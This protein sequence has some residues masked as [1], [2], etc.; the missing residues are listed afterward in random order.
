MRFL[1]DNALSP[2]V[3]EALRQAGHDATHVRE[4]KMQASPDPLVF[5]RAVSEDRILVSA[6]TDFAALLAIRNETKPSLILFRGASLRRPEVQ[7]QLM[8]E[9]LPRLVTDLARG[10]VVVLQEN[11]IRVRTLPIFVDRTED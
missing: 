7:A 10:C 1:V 11:R 5:E 8:L 4:Y 2:A 3:A 6:D 9:Q